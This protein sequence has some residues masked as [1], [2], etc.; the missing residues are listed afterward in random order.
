MAYF[1]VYGMDQS[2]MAEKREQTRSAHREYIREPQLGCRCVLGG[3]LLDETGDGMV[4]TTLV[5]EGPDLQSVRQFIADDPYV[6]AGLFQRLDIFP[7]RIGL[8]SISGEK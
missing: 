7:W 8:G 3:P 4:G 6:V 1:I 2:G 5:V